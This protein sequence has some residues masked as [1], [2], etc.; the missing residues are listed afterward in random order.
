MTRPEAISQQKEMEVQ[1]REPASPRLLPYIS[2]TAVNWTGLVAQAFHA[3]GEI[4]SLMLPALPD[5]SLT[6]LAGGT[7]HTA[8]RPVNGPWQE[9]QMRQG[10]LTLS[11]NEGAFQEEMS[12]KSLS[13]L[14]TQILQ[15]RL[16]KGLLARAAQDMLGCDLST[17][18]LPA[19]VGFQD[20]LLT[21]IGLALW[22]ELEQPVPTSNLYAQ[23][24]AQMLA[25]H[26]LRYY[27]SQGSAAKELKQN[28]PGLTKRQLKQVRDFILVHLSQDLSLEDLA[29]Q[30]GF[31]PSHFARLFRQATGESPHQFVLYQRVE[32]ARHLLQETEA[33]L[34][35]IAAE[36]GF[37]NQSH[38]TTV[39]KDY[40]GLTPRTYRRDR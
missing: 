26:L 34:I 1:N 36:C 21:Q 4:E 14:P 16:S 6:L 9:A 2:S 20:P 13:C 38:L 5:I 15:L 24:A 40:F 8:Y 7:L 25:V 39:F 27:T 31:S 22:R 11:T 23:S 28:L 18:S 29:S 35:Q 32:R 33:P 3:P 19:R 10:D 30:I 12:W 17:L 37:A